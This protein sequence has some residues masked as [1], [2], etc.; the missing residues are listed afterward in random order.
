MKRL[1]SLLWLLAVAVFFASVDAV[2]AQQVVP[3]PSGAM[4]AVLNKLFDSMAFTGKADFRVFDHSMKETTSMP[5]TYSM[6]DGR[7]RFDVDV[8]RMKS[9][10]MAAEGAAFM[11]TLGQVIAVIRPDKKLTIQIYPAVK[12]YT[13]TPMSKEDEAELL[14]NFKVE[15]TGMGS[16]TVS[17]HP[18]EKQRVLLTDDK[19]QVQQALVWYATDLKEFPVQVQMGDPNQTFL[20]T[21]SQVKLGRPD[22]K[23]FEAPAGMTRYTEDQM[24]KKLTALATPK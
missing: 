3:G 1:S 4:S 23:L 8:T 2:P 5:I 6:L 22:S 14:K 13:E 9:S 11:H 12:G 7:T 24:V 15:K 19:G 20:L 10:Q 17:G 21:F 18:C 16:E